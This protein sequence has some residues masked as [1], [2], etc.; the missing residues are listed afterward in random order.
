MLIQD[1]TRHLKVSCG[2]VHMSSSFF[3]GGWVFFMAY[4]TLKDITSEMQSGRP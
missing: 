3:W 2:K 4:I 1:K